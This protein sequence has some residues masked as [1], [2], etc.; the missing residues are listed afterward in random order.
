MREKYSNFV[1]LKNL[2]LNLTPIMRKMLV[3]FKIICYLL[4]LTFNRIFSLMVTFLK[5]ILYDCTNYKIVCLQ[6][7]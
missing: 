1:I 6:Q 3:K 4:S 5:R 2:Y 7:Q